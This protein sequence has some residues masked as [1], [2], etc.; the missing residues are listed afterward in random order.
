[1]ERAYSLGEFA[2]QNDIGLTTVRGETQS[3]RLMARKVGRDHGGSCDC[4]I[5][6]NVDR[7]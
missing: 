1:M 4:E 5:L 6:L 7:W 3:G 2:R